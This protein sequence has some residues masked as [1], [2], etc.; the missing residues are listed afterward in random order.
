VKG[1]D[2][3][4]DRFKCPLF[5]KFIIS[6]SGF[7]ERDRNTIKQYVEREGATYSPSLIKDQCTHLIC[8]EPKG[9]L[10]YTNK[11]DDVFCDLGSKYEHA[12]KWRIPVLKPEWIFDS[13]EK[14]SCLRLTN[15]L[16]PKL[17]IDSNSS[18]GDF[19]FKII[20]RYLTF[21]SIENEKP[22]SKDT[23][24]SSSKIVEVDQR[25][26]STSLLTTEDMIDLE[27]RFDKWMN[28]RSKKIVDDLFDG[29][30]VC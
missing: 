24:D 20:F 14:G 27:E 4:F 18:K 10:R 5:Y 2:S 21:C 1:T 25:R 22:S 26:K 28:N 13:S 30:K 17:N 6:L 11:I 19:L 29:L 12:I 3:T 7:A 9:R 23:I 16:W 8:K 15:F